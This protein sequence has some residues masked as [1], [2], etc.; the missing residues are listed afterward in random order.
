MIF[1]ILIF[2]CIVNLNIFYDYQT[3]IAGL[4][5]L[6]GASYVLKAT[7]L[8][9]Q[10]S[11]N[12]E[13]IKEFNASLSAFISSLKNLNALYEWGHSFKT[14]SIP[15]SSN[16]HLLWALDKRNDVRKLVEEKIVN[17][18][19]LY[20]RIKLL[21]DIDNQLHQ[22]LNDEINKFFIRSRELEMDLISGKRDI[23]N[24]ESLSQ[25]DKKLNEIESEIMRISREIIKEK[26]NLPK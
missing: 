24:K 22:Q 7:K 1:F 16:E 25:I 10:N 4:A 19:N 23:T 21:I 6:L 3:L 13:W 14:D 15:F 17:K 8:Q 5:A 2:L 18:D 9:I 11:K 20:L 26:Q 12:I